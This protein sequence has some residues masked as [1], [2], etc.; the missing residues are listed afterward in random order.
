MGKREKMAKPEMWAKNGAK[1]QERK[2]ENRQMNFLKEK[3]EIVEFSQK[4]SQSNIWHKIKFN[5]WN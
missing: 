4:L 5:W 1:G 2:N 3:G